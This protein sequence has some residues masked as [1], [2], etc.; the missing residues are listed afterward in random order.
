MTEGEFDVLSMWVYGF[1]NVV[2]GT[3]GATANWKEDWLD[4]LE[5]YKSF[6]LLYDDDQA[7]N[8]GAE[9][10]ADKLGKYRCFRSLIDGFNDPNEALIAG[11]TSDEI[12]AQINEFESFVDPKLARVDDFQAELEQIIMNPHQNRGDSTGSNFTR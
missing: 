4:A 5:K 11:L 8:E 1:K 6:I 3:A 9:K 2:S 7:G 12:N 10:L